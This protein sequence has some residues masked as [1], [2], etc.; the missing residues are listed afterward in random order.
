MDSEPMAVQK[1]VVAAEGAALVLLERMEALKAL[2]AMAVTL[3]YMDYHTEI[4]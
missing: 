4:L 3:K 1:Q 2:G